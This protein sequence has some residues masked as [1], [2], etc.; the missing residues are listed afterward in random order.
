VGW[1]AWADCPLSIK[2]LRVSVKWND[3]ALR[4]LCSAGQILQLPYVQSMIA[5]FVKHNQLTRNVAGVQA[6]TPNRRPLYVDYIFIFIKCCI[7]FRTRMLLVGLNG[8]C[9]FCPAYNYNGMCC[10]T[11]FSDLTKK[12]IEK[13]YHTDIGGCSKTALFISRFSSCSVVS[14]S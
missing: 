8:S 5:D 1:T 13:M 11:K 4:L 2:H 3:V 12:C 6:S 9:K 10:A 7:F 14:L